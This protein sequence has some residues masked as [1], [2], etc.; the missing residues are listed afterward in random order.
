LVYLQIP[1]ENYKYRVKFL[2][3]INSVCRFCNGIYREYRQLDPIT[4]SNGFVVDNRFE[5]C[6]YDLY[7]RL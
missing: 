4:S 2:I 1:L 7:S 5:L 3:F 6:C